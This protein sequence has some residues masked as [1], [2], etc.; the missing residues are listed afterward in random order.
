MRFFALSS[1]VMLAVPSRAR[2]GGLKYLRW[3]ERAA[4]FLL[5][6]LS[7]VHVFFNAARSMMVGRVFL[8][9]TGACQFGHGVGGFTTNF[10]QMSFIH[11][12]FN[13]RKIGSGMTAMQDLCWLDLE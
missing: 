4:F 9:L 13:A 6:Y 7:C 11:V 10:I 5:F 1:R 3:L 8:V 2:N 12:F